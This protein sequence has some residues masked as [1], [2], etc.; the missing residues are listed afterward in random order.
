LVALTAPTGHGKTTVA[1]AIQVALTTERPF[2]GR[3]VTGGSVAVLAGE[4]PTD[5]AMHLMATLQEMQIKPDELRRVGLTT[6]DLLIV[7]GTFDITYHLD[8]LESLLAMGAW[9]IGRGLCRY[10]GRVLHGRRGER[11]R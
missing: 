1:A 3:Q 6:T 7:P 2:A 8:H 4:N 10:V 9:R 5:Y 11:E